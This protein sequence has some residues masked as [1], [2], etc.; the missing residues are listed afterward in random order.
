MMRYQDPPE[1]K[2]FYIGVNVDKRIRKNHPLRKIFI[3]SNLIEAALVHPSFLLIT[4]QLSIMKSL[5]GSIFRGS[6]L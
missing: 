3:D 6:N 5:L 1:S 4:T 2:L